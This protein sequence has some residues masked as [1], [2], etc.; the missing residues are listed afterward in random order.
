[1][2]DRNDRQWY[3]DAVIY[4]VHVKSFFDSNDNGIGDFVGLTS[5]LDYIREL[6]ANAIWLM[7]F[8]P[9]PLRDDGYDIADYRGINPLYGEMRDFR[10]FIKEAHARSLRV[11]TELVVNH[12]SDQHPWFIKARHSKPGSP[13]RDFYV[14]SDNP[15]QYPGVP[16][17]F[18]D[19]EK[20]NWTWDP[21]AGAYFW[22]RFYSHQPDLNYDNPK[23]LEAVLDNMRFWLDMGV[24]GLRLDAIPYL[25]EREGTS[26]ESLPET[27]AIIRRIRA[28]I[29]KDYPDRM[30]IAEANLWPED[31]IQYFGDGDECHMAF[32]FPLMPRMYMAV[33][34]EDR[35]PI[36]DI[37]RQTPE[38]PEGGQW[39]IFLRNHDELTLATVTDRE[40]DYLWEYFANDKRA[41]FSLGI[42]RRLAPLLGNDRRKIEL[43]TSLLLSMP[44]T[45]ILYYGDEI[46]M[47]DNI[48]LGD[49]DGVRT[50]MQ[51]SPDRNGGFS[52]ADP[53]RLYLPAIQDAIYGYPAV[54]V[55]AQATSPGS[56]LNW[57]RRMVAVRRGQT[58]L[59]R[60]TLHFIYPA[61]RKV[62]AYVREHDGTRILCVANVS[63]SPQAVELDLSDYRGAT[64][65]EMT[66]GSVFPP[67]GDTHYLL[68]LPAYGFYWF[69]LAVLTPSEQKF[70]PPT[71]PGLFTLVL[72]GE[73]QTIL[74]GRERVAFETTI[75]PTFLGKQW[76]FAGKR[77]RID[78]LAVEDFAVMRDGAGAAKYLLTDVS[79][80]LRDGRQ[81]SYFMPLAAELEGEDDALL[82]Y[83]FAR[84]RRG[85]KVGLLFDAAS[86]ADFAMAVV[87]AIDAKRSISS[88]GDA[89]IRFRPT[90]AFC[91]V[92]IDRHQVRR[93]ASEQA[94]SSV[95]LDGSYILK[96]VR[97]L[98]RGPHPEVEVGAFLTERGLFPQAPALTGVVERIA[99]DGSV[100]A[101]MLLHR[102]IAHQGDA[103]TVMMDALK[104]ELDVGVFA[105]ASHPALAESMAPTLR[106]AELIGRRTGELHL[107]L[108]SGERGTAFST[109]PLT[110]DDLRRSA[111]RSEAMIETAFS[112]LETALYELPER[113]R[114]TI[115]ALL[116]RRGD[117]SRLMRGLAKLPGKACKSRIHGD[118][119]LGQVLVV[120]D[121]IAIVDFDGE[122]GQ[123]AEDRLGKY[124]P[125]RDVASM[126]RS[127]AYVAETAARDFS[128]RF[129]ESRETAQ[130]IAAEW[131]GF[132]SASFMAGYGAATEGMQPV[133][134]AVRRQLIDF[135]L[136]QRTLYEIIYE[137]GTRPGWIGLPARGLLQALNQPPGER[138]ALRQ[139]VTGDV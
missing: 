67:I 35:H 120:K 46:G 87:D 13:A 25:I 84:T 95:V 58:A 61:N 78:R 88:A 121:D 138:A 12:T 107:A 10:R 71:D 113:D 90:S 60:G 20:S 106:L 57:N 45:P 101:L 76:W 5:K 118:Y 125:L 28:E 94:N 100:S 70:A 72:S 47:G 2:I 114:H 117:L 59:S 123:P 96:F 75:A 122:P 102:L 14:W 64:L 105:A 26:C 31:A 55:E 17:I 92:A 36:T 135:H 37:L 43:L 108:G 18:L 16:I 73:L 82:P 85:P 33:A 66:G 131:E 89:V 111:E 115:D 139:S 40:R 86:S 77:S 7:P 3:R 134:P 130:A 119:H 137:A 124:S 91:A 99:A 4:Q 9:S 6:G 133:D 80:S 98:H 62:L 65:V 44:G 103:A 30:L 129:A 15:D 48:Y 54:N 49:R 81:Q 56:L 127:F 112:A 126:L 132:A 11:I 24:D 42:R 83:G 53:A 63:G 97:T 39:G 32:H 27:H 109:E 52:R 128:D 116:K 22:H 19:T 79:V 41:R 50:P 93:L 29:D 69:R 110:K 51:W 23:V 21:V 136:I 34:R 8:Y 74:A 38:L 104:R 1:M 68:T